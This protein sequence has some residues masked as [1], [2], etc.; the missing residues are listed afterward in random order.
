MR[1]H[2]NLKSLANALARAPGDEI[3]FLPVNRP[4]SGLPELL[5][6][7]KNIGLGRSRRDVVFH[8]VAHL[9]P[10]SAQLVCALK[11]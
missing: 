6:P 9:E 4:R 5:I 7:S 1:I 2:N 10:G 3:D 11:V 8:L